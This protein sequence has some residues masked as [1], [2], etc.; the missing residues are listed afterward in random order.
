VNRAKLIDTLRQQAGISKQDADSVV[1]MFFDEMSN[2]LGKGDRVE[3]RGFCS[4]R[5]RRYRPYTGINPKT[6]DRFRVKA[7]RLPVFKC[8]MELKN[9]VNT[10]RNRHMKKDE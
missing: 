7:K 2:A 1:R 8:G 9:R 10:D 6:G 4:F 3:L 5:V